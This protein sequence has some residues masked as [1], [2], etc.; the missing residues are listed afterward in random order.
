MLLGLGLLVEGELRGIRS[1][2]LLYA[3]RFERE[4]ELVNACEAQQDRDEFNETFTLHL[5]EK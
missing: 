1:R 5:N 3:T 2:L 4:R